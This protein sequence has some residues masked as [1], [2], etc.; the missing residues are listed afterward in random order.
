M[1]GTRYNMLFEFSEL[2]WLF[3]DTE[4]IESFLNR[5]IDLIYKHMK[6]TGCS[7][8]LIDES[9]DQ[10]VFMASEQTVGET[11]RTLDRQKHHL[12]RDDGL[13]GKAVESGKVEFDS[14]KRRIMAVPINRGQMPIGVM[15][16][17]RRRR[18]FKHIDAATMRFLA[19]QL[20]NILENART[21]MMDAKNTGIEQTYS[22]LE[23]NTQITL[24]GTGASP[25]PA[26]GNSF[27]LDRKRSFTELRRLR[28]ER[29]YT[30]L[31]LSKAIDKTEE[32][33]LELQ[34]GVEENLSD[35]ASLIFTS[36]LLILKD[37]SF[38]NEI[39]SRI[40]TGIN[41]P[42]ALLAVAENYIKLFAE[43]ENPVVREKVEDLEDL[44]QRIFANLL[45]D[46]IA[47][48][49]AGGRIVI[50]KSLYPSDILMLASERTAGI[51]LVSGGVTSHISILAQSLKIP[52]VILDFTDLLKTDKPLPIVL[53]GESG[54]ICINPN[55]DIV[56]E[57]QEIAK[58]SRK[59]ERQ[60]L[61][62]ETVTKC[63][64]K[65]GLYTNIN[66]I[67]DLEEAIKMNAEGIGL[68]RTEFPF[69]LRNSLPTEEEQYSIYK[70]VIEL[71]G[72]RPITFRTLD[73][74]GDKVL[75]YY[76]DYSE[77]NP[78]LGL[79]SIR[80]SLQNPAIFRQ[81]IRAILR[82]AG[83]KRIKLMFPMIST[84]EELRTAKDL[85]LQSFEELQED[86]ESPVMPEIGAMI[87]IPSL[88]AILDHICEEVDFLSIGTNDFIQ[89][90]LAVDRNNEKLKDYYIPHNPSVLRGLKMIADV[91]AAH[92]IELTVCGEMAHQREYIPFLLGI[93]IK[94]LSVST[95]FLHETQQIIAG[96]HLDEARDLADE[97]ISYSS[98]Y[99]IERR[100]GIQ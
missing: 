89:Y 32:Q 35:S 19:S 64:K 76:R 48:V 28:F 40:I 73:V 61:I 11:G 96:T 69:L 4:D 60:P 68:Y 3:H 20:A 15:R 94:N 51:L 22:S 34:K 12:K 50:A 44:I 43:N 29:V 55:Q 78:F 54:R 70:Q 23:F 42:A 74:G 1:L 36:H 97:I 86:G 21:F 91:S 41:P 100:L 8:Y 88:L 62:E 30:Y 77:E 24:Q 72:N 90:M 93:G 47:P 75:S 59:N 56:D 6:I 39:K 49:N 46:D 84:M 31:E 25:G 87:E 26:Y 33:L 38:N 27:T 14:R 53:D 16:L 98:T 83:N 13:Y 5:I 63:G 10:L 79:R 17:E 18:P 45:G 99:E 57:F 65:I 7:I 2:D 37:K 58:R 95:A 82:A 92:N 67:P 52:M 9:S 80:F 71:S 81:Q 66:L 85:V